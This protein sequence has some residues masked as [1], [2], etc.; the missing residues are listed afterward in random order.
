[1]SKQMSRFADQGVSRTRLGVSILAAIV[2]VLVAS[3]VAV[4]RSSGTPPMSQGAPR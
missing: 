2:A 1:M 4:S 3:Q